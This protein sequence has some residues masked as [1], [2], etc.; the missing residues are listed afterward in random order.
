M[1]APGDRFCFV[2]PLP[3]AAALPSAPR[4]IFIPPRRSQRP[5]AQRCLKTKGRT[6]H[7]KDK[8]SW[9]WN[10]RTHAARG[11]GKRA[12]EESQ[13]KPRTCSWETHGQ[14][15][16]RRQRSKQ[17]PQ[18]AGGAGEVTAAEVAA[19]PGHLG[20]A[21]AASRGPPEWCSCPRSSCCPWWVWL[22]I[23][24]R[25]SWGGGG[26]RSPIAPGSAEKR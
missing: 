18:H 9:D 23:T 15:G 6:G 20:G 22:E 8:R 16:K 25:C 11:G 12:E 19:Q 7:M 5:P 3:G 10:K 13:G 4:H 14:P 21:L 24:A 17:P 2:Q 1:P 26:H